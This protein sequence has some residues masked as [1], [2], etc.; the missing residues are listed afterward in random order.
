[1]TKAARPAMT[2]ARMGTGNLGT[3]INNVLRSVLPDAPHNRCRKHDIGLTS[4]KSHKLTRRNLR[5]RRV[6]GLISETAPRLTPETC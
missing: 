2:P 4:L 3:L 6:R 5:D 1:V